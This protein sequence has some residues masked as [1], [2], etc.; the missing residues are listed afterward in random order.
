M[1]DGQ[2]AEVR[3]ILDERRRDSTCLI[4]ENSGEPTAVARRRSA[5]CRAAKSIQSFV[6]QLTEPAIVTEA[7]GFDN[8]NVCQKSIDILV[9]VCEDSGSRRGELKRAAFIHD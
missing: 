3:E 9:S 5:V 8:V 2:D 6:A 7:E 1:F 4:G